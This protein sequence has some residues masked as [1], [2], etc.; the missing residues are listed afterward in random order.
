ME[1][2]K[3]KEALLLLGR[4]HKLGKLEKE[5]DRARILQDCQPS[6]AG[7]GSAVA[8]DGSSSFSCSPSMAYD[9]DE[10]MSTSSRKSPSVGKQSDWWSAD[11][12]G[13]MEAGGRSPRPKA[14]PG[15]P[16][17]QAD[18]WSARKVVTNEE[19]E[20]VEGTENWGQGMEVTR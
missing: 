11:L 7:S 4:K 13:E 18:H 6:G 17:G 12:E 16:K 3:A 8:A 2:Q 19:G 10:S 14:D 9:V 5:R 1:E 20:K 15:I